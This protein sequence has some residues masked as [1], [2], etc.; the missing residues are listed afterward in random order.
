MAS[1]LRDTVN[2]YLK[3]DKADKYR[4]SLKAKTLEEILRIPYKSIS[5]KLQKCE[6]LIEKANQTRIINLVKSTKGKRYNQLLNYYEISSSK[7]TSQ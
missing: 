1:K 3:Y 5:S 6:N 4:L 7:S 2:K